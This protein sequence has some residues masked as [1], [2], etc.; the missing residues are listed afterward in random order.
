MRRL[1]VLAAVLA[2]TVSALPASGAATGEPGPGYIATDNVEWLGNI[3]INADSAGGRLLDGYFYISDDRGLTIYD[4]SKPESPQRVGFAIVPQ[5]AYYVEEDLDTNGEI[6][7]IG[8]YGDL[9]PAND[10]PLNRLIVVDVKDKANPKVIGELEGVDSHTV[11]C[12]LDC[13]YAYNSNGQIIDLRDPSAPKLVGNWATGTPVKGSHDVSEVAPGIVLTSSNPMVLLDANADPAKPTMIGGGA[14]PDKRFMHGNLW[15]RGGTD[16]F[17]LAG[18][19]TSGDCKDE[20]DGGFMTF[21]PT[22]DETTGQTTMTMVDDFHLKTGL[23]TD[24]NSP[25][26]QFCAHWFDT[27][28]TY[29]DGGLVAMGWYEHGTRFLDVSSEGKITEKGWFYPLGGS[30]SAAY[31]V[32]DKIVYSVDYQRGIDILKFTDAPATGTTEVAASPGY[33]APLRTRAPMA[34]MAATALRRDPF[35]CP[36]PGV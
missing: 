16:K 8:S 26:D 3:P 18:G 36:L 32:T 6:A 17:V 34:S 21:A 10:G 25:Y 2:L 29:A 7:L 4:V 9:S 35:A 1:F 31:W 12:V 19:E 15:P 23:P 22:T 5:G 27:H 28:P 20:S 14:P 33:V 30:T 13:T 24:G 11:T